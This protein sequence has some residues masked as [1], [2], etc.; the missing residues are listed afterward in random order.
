MYAKKERNLICTATK[1][2]YISLLKF[3][4]SLREIKSQIQDKQNMYL[5]LSVGCNVIVLIVRGISSA[6]H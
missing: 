5:A 2:T 6:T 3:G 4:E 1:S